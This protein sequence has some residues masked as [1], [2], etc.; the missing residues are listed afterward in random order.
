[1]CSIKRGFSSVLESAP[2]QGVRGYVAEGAN[3]RFPQDLKIVGQLSQHLQLSCNWWNIHLTEKTCRFAG[4]DGQRSV[5]TASKTVPVERDTVFLFFGD[6][7]RIARAGVRS[8]CKDAKQGT[9]PGNTHPE[10]EHVMANV[11][12][13]NRRR[14]KDR[15]AGAKNRRELIAAGFN[16]QPS[17]RW[18]QEPCNASCVLR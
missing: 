12:K 11:S 10:G 18:Q 14:E 7:T 16:S 4:P 9:V 3:V 6:W 8:Y 13:R 5:S 15:H 1:M 17:G 2:R